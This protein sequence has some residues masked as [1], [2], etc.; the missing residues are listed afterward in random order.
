[1]S[2]ELS[3]MCKAININSRVGK[4]QVLLRFSSIEMKNFLKEMLRHGYI[5]GFSIIDDKFKGKTIIDLNGRLNR[6]GAICPNF[7]VKKTGVEAF[8]TKLLPARQFGH[9]LFNTSQGFIDHNECQAHGIGGKILGY[10]Y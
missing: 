7:R 1:M 4:R 10:F 2:K 6:C 5:S 8:R 3:Q 9:V